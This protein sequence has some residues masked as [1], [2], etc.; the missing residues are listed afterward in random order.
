MQKYIAD[1]FYVFTLKYNVQH[2]HITI[3]VYTYVY[4]YIEHTHMFVYW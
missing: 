1:M 2:L 3:Y 4:I